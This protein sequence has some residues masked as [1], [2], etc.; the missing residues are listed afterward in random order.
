MAVKNRPTRQGAAMNWSA[1][2]YI[3]SLS[4][5][6]GYK[7]YKELQPTLAAV[8]AIR[9]LKLMRSSVRNLARWR[10]GEHVL[11]TIQK[12]QVRSKV[13]HQGI[14]IGANRRPPYAARR[15]V[16]ITWYVM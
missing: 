13:T 7:R 12:A 11:E 9:L 6:Y 5:A 14:R 1:A 4:F 8:V 3:R 2:T 10:C 15:V 16:R